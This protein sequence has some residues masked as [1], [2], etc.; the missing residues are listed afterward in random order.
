[1]FA[2]FV[3]DASGMRPTGANLIEIDAAS[4][5]MDTQAFG[6]RSISDLFR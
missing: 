2:K 1:M 6:F 4:L 3:T 5:S